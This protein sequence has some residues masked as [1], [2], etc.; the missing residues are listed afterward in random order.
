[1]LDDPARSRNYPCLVTNGTPVSRRFHYWTGASGARY[2]HSVFA[3]EETPVFDRAV[4]V[5]ARRI[6]AD[7]HDALA[8]GRFGEG[9]PAGYDA[10]LLA[11]LAREGADEVHLHLLA[12]SDWEAAR[13]VADLAAGQDCAEF[14]AA[15]CI[16]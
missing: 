13:I 10:G 3:I 7:R 15:G 12:D 11:R 14:V 16:L 9:A 6:D 8:V 1:M 4:F 2:L 5:I